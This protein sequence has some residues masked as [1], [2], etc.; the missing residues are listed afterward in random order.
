MH[1]LDND[2]RTVTHFGTSLEIPAAKSKDSRTVT[3]FGA[4]LGTRQ[5]LREINEGTVVARLGQG[6][7]DSYILWDFPR[8]SSGQEQG[9]EDSYTLWRFSWDETM[10][11][12]N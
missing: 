7:E 2:L 3:H 1:G 6:F 4:S 9:F 5:C 11:A 12:G 10:L 8:D